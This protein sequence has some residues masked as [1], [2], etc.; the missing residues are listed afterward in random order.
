MSSGR[1]TV[2]DFEGKHQVVYIL[3]IIHRRHEC[4]DIG[5]TVSL[6]AGNSNK[7]WICL[8]HL[9]LLNN[10]PQVF[11]LSAL[12]FVWVCMRFLLKLSSLFV[13]QFL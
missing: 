13:L 5:W 4:R 9:Y 10:P 2:S 1:P 12:K 8:A 6:K 7:V 11:S 3:L